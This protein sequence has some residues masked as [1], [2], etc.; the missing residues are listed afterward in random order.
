MVLLLEGCSSFCEP[1]LLIGDAA[2]GVLTVDA[3]LG[4]LTVD[5]ALGVLTVDA[6]LVEDWLCENLHCDPGIKIM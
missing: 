6:G 3:A 2:L 5:A 4:V 1:L